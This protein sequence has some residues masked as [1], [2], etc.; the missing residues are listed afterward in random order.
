MI[1][2]CTL[3]AGMQYAFGPKRGLWFIIPFQLIVMVGTLSRNPLMLCMICIALQA[4][5]MRGM[6]ALWCRWGW[7]LC[8]V[9]LEVGANTSAASKCLRK[10]HA[11]KHSLCMLITMGLL[12]RRK[13]HACSVGLLLPQALPSLRDLRLDCSFCRHAAASLPGEPWQPV[14]KKPRPEQ[15]REDL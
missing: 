15:C 9:S 8:T 6:S 13:E 2:I 14:V 11:A 7:P 10:G 3:C 4:M 12:L 1:L 5:G